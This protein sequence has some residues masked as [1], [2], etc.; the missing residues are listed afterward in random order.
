MGRRYCYVPGC[1]NMSQ[2]VKDGTKGN[3]H[4]LP[5]SGQ[6]NNIKQQWIRRLRNVRADLIIASAASVAK[7]HER[8]KL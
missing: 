6:K 4:R 8:S 7:R 3:L 1:S 2:T 5:M